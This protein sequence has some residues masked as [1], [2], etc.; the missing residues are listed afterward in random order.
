LAISLSV[1][2]ERAAIQAGISRTGEQSTT[3]IYDV[4][5][6]LGELRLHLT[7]TLHLMRDIDRFA[8]KDDI[9]NVYDM[10]QE[11]ATSVEAAIDPAKLTVTLVSS[12]PARTI[13][14]VKG[15]TKRSYRVEDDTTLAQFRL[16]LQTDKVIE[17][18]DIFVIDGADL[19]TA[20]ER[21]VLIKILKDNTL[22][23]KY[24]STLSGPIPKPTVPTM[25][26]PKVE[27]SQAVTYQQGGA[28]AP[29]VIKGGTFDNK[30]EDKW[31]NLTTEQKRSIYNMLQL[32]R[33]M[34]VGTS[35][36]LTNG[37]PGE[38]PRSYRSAVL[39]MFPEERNHEPLFVA[40]NRGFTS[41]F[42]STFSLTAHELHKRAVSTAKAGAGVKGAAFTSEVNVASESTE[43]QLQSRLYMSQMFV[44]PVVKLKTDVKT[45]VKPNPEFSLAIWRALY[46]S[47]QGIHRYVK[48][49]EV[50]KEFGHFLPTEFQLGGAAF[51][52]ERAMVDKRKD[53]K[54]NSFS[55]KSGLE[56]TIKGVEL[57]AGVG[58]EQA[59]KNENEDQLEERT[60]ET[61][62]IGGDA[63]TVAKDSY[64]E[65]LKSLKSH[66]YWKVIKY[67]AF[68][69]TIR[70][71]D[72]RL[73]APCLAV[74]KEYA[75][76]PLTAQHTCIDMMD[77]A[78]LA[79]AALPGNDLYD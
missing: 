39:L 62:V 21:D 1:S 64:S 57:S 20:G 38:I 68:V 11:A 76:D 73:L 23:V 26:Y 28:I 4:S 61:F 72:P 45:D 53:I 50:L 74:L 32:G 16:T 6:K 51:F 60:T 41:K 9:T 75:K 24:S 13:I 14:V 3:I 30:D 36:A 22:N 29:P 78:L 54:M 19:R 46:E 33:A 8:N 79:E 67:D 56:G 12:K 37:E 77:Y 5:K 35:D 47:G 63:G 27:W 44:K 59:Q 10:G 48:L 55:T 43:H 42:L 69:P 2:G 52:E 18:V 34:I 7:Q 49:L 58:H 66:T 70:F 15:E 17:P 31:P 25:P 71:L 65:W 40:P